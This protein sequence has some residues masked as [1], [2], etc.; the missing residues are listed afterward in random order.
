MGEGPGGRLGAPPITPA[1]DNRRVGPT[2]QYWVAVAALLTAGTGGWLLARRSPGRVATVVGR[3]ISV[4]LLLDAVTYVV[5]LGL[6]DGWTL[7]GSL[8][9]DLCDVALV[10]AAITCWIPDWALGVELTY[11]W[12]LAGTLQ[13]VVTPDLSA[14]FP[15]LQFLEF[16]VGHV[17]VVVAAGYLVIGVRREPR[18]GAVLRISA[19]TVAYAVVVGVIDALTGA[20]YMYLRHVPRHASLLSELGPWPWYIPSA[21][22]VA[23]VLFA[24]LDGPF[25]KRRSRRRSEDTAPLTSS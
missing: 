7:R 5:D 11:F 9:V 19:V 3:V 16:V 13:A 22:G 20:N 1:E 23:I 25:W 6:R 10:I 8:P 17:G 2:A 18:P 15:Q 24:V 4:V 21:A 12:G 14:R